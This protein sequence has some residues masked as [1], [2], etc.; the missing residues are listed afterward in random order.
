MSQ[1]LLTAVVERLRTA[2]YQLLGSRVRVGSIPY[3]FSGVLLGPEGTLD[4]VLVVDS[5]SIDGLDRLPQRIDGVG[6]ALDMAGSRRTITVVVAGATPEAS[7]LSAITAVGRFL[8]VP[9]A[10]RIDEEWIDDRLATLLPLELD[11]VADND[12]EPIQELLRRLDLGANDERRALIAAASKGAPEVEA[13]LRR[14]IES[15]LG[16]GAAND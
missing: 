3:E 12:S 4:L 14:L 2:G 6:R 16:A 10:P 15:S 5:D 11:V 13:E 7:V 9:R 8:L 1:D